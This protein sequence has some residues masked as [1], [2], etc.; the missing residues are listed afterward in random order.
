MQKTSREF[1][2]ELGVN[3]LSERKTDE[4]TST[5]LAYITN[6]L[7]KGWKVLDLACGY[8]RFAIPLASMGYRVEG[9][10]TTPIFIERAREE[11]AKRNLEIDFKVGDM[12]GLPYEDNSFDSVICMWNAF[13]ELATEQEQVSAILE[14]HRVLRK[15][16]MA[17][18]EVRNHTSSGLEEANTIDGYEAMPS[19]NHTR[20][21]LRRL[22]EL[23]KISGYKVFIDNFGGRKRLILKIGKGN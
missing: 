14:I 8:G 21:S 11:A 3:W 18:V 5:E 17:L 1:Y 7:G 20:G 2:S 19:Y 15:G 6:L 16:G 12:T 23:S 10:D 22:M 9:I 4:H 13:S